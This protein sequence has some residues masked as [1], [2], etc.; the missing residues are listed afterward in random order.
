MAV[1]AVDWHI[2]ATEAS[3]SNGENFQTLVVCWMIHRYLEIASRQVFDG[4]PVKIFILWNCSYHQT[5]AAA[6]V[7]PL[8]PTSFFLAPPQMAT[9]GGALYSQLSVMPLKSNLIAPFV[10]WKL[11]QDHNTV[12]E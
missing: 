8:V 11:L 1:C 6:V 4:M 7:S 9:Q 10:S 3:I 2:W 12:K 5:Q